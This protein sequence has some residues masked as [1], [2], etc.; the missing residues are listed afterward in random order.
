MERKRFGI[1]L[2][3]LFVLA[4]C[5]PAGEAVEKKGATTSKYMAPDP[6]VSVTASDATRA[7][8]GI[9]EWRIYRGKGGVYLTG[10]D[11][12][13]QAV[14]GLAT[15]F[16]RNDDGT[17]GHVFT[18][19]NDGSLFAVRHTA[20]THARM[21]TKAVSVSSQQFVRRAALDLALLQRIALANARTAPAGVAAVQATCREQLPSVMLQSL[22]CLDSQNGSS[23]LCNLEPLVNGSGAACLGSTS[24]A[25]V[26]GSLGTLDATGATRVCGSDPACIAAFATI[27]RENLLDARCGGAIAC[28]GAGGGFIPLA[29]FNGAPISGGGGGVFPPFATGTFNVVGSSFDPRIDG[30]NP[31]S[32]FG[33]A[34][35]GSGGTGGITTGGGVQIFSVPAVTGQTSG[36]GSEV[37][38]SAA[39]GVP[40]NRFQ[41]ASNPGSEVA[42][43]AAAGV[44]DNRFQPASNPGSEVA[45]SA[46]AG[47]PDNRFEPAPTS[48]ALNSDAGNGAVSFGEGSPDGSIQE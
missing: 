47:V 33:P 30:V 24:A 29:N 27:Q 3:G 25:N 22:A 18:R 28:V 43:S 1:V 19:V 36:P 2:M 32:P 4:G 23:A 40:D 34:M 38:A 13:G 9:D 20:S 31:S 12:A 10:Y 35:P 7:A 48:P 44:P 46:A 21:A 11:T 5:Q 42:A 8:T 15:T 6:I 39:A 45:A 37:A 17:V 16:A 26:A 14:K 41:P